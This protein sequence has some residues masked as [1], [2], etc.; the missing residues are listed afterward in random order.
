MQSLKY[1]LMKYF[2]LKEARRILP[3][4]STL[5][6]D[7]MR[8]KKAIDLLNNIELEYPENAPPDINPIKLNREFHRL[9]Y[10]FYKILDMLEETGC[11]VK[12][13]DH[14]LV[15]FYSIQNDKEI[16]FCWKVGEEDITH[17]HDVDSGFTGRMP[18]DFLEQQSDQER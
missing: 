9:S 1:P 4:V 11:V 5:L 6:H 13:I 17:W 12:D 10:E 3:T 7:L 14:G 15:D 8:T 16:F 2:T 18:I